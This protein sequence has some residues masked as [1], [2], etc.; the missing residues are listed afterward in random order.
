VLVV[1]DTS[2]LR[3][4][5]SLGLLDLLTKL[6][7]QV[8]IPPAVE[9]E[10]SKGNAFPK[11][12]WLKV[13]APG[14]RARVEEL[15]ARLGPGESE[16]IALALELGAEVLIDERAGRSAAVQLGLETTGVLGVLLEAKSR[17]HV[18]EVRPLIEALIARIQFRISTAVLDQTLRAA[19][20]L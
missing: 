10:L 5:E 1:S 19:G 7:G 11:L 8:L 13:V 9:A 16:A 18:G 14:D 3:A 4:L 20:E 12:P 15:Q 6:Y 17:G 2:P